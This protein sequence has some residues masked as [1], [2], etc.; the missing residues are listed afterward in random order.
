MTVPCQ[1]SLPPYLPVW[2]I[3]KIGRHIG[4][5]QWFTHAYHILICDGEQILDNLWFQIQK[6]H[7]SK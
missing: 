2:A 4:Y 3:C 6:Y 1:R 5:L 7:S